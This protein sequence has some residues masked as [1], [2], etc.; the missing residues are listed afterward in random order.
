MPVYFFAC[1]E[2]FD[3]AVWRL[4]DS[5]VVDPDLDPPRSVPRNV[6]PPWGWDTILALY[7]RSG[8][9]GLPA[10]ASDAL[11][12]YVEGTFPDRLET[13]SWITRAEVQVHAATDPA[14]PLGEDFF[15]G[16]ARDDPGAIRLVFWS[17]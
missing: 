4:A 13:V 9:R 11:R 14:F 10:D 6:A 8:A 2:W 17:D 15:G 7:E 5:S 12:C 3:G 1:V 16:Y